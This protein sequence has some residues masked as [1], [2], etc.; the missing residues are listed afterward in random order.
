MQDNED[1]G[2]DQEAGD[3][4]P[5]GMEHA[6]RE[7]GALAS[8]LEDQW[9]GGA[10]AYAIESLTKT[11]KQAAVQIAVMPKFADT[12]VGSDEQWRLFDRAARNLELGS[13]GP[14]MQSFLAK[15]AKDLRAFDTAGERLRHFDHWSAVADWSERTL[16]FTALTSWRTSLAM[17]SHFERMLADV[18]AVQLPQ[19]SMVK[20]L[21]SIT[22]A[23][24][25]FT[26]WVVQQDASSRLLGEISG[27]PLG[28][29]RSYVDSLP[30]EPDDRVLLTSVTTGFV[31]LGL[32]GADVLQPGV[33]DAGFVELA[34]EHVESDILAPWDRARLRSAKE[35]YARL[36]EIEPTVPEL[37]Y[38]AWEEVERNG[39][40]AVSKTAHCAVEALDRTLRAAAPEK[41]V[42]GWHT[43][44]RRPAS[45]LSEHGKVTHPLRIRYLGAQ[46]GGAKKLIVEQYESLEALFSPLR[47]RLEGAKHASIGDLTTA[48]NLLMT[49]EAF[50]SVLFMSTEP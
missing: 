1:T 16:G 17:E 37:L 26:D 30:A 31:G 19:L 34:V 47:G 38:A 50:L 49:T 12:F 42:L 18:A 24:V 45:E 20:D 41:V 23:Q 25:R 46:A 5:A 33:N 48:R 9:D 43:T 7:S 4:L 32:L 10:Q 27:R 14:G 35:L 36:G 40:A 28:L 21:A 15:V 13:V 3:R 29:W 22:K 11:L 2:S 8:Y 44:T 6:L 39:P